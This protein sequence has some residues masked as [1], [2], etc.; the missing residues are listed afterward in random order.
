LDTNL[1]TPYYPNAAALPVEPINVATNEIP[2]NVVVN[3]DPG[4]SF[5]NLPPVAAEAREYTIANKDTLS[6]IAKTH[7]VSLRE[8]SKANPNID[9]ARLKVGQKI[10][11][12]AGTGAPATPAANVAADNSKPAA[13]GKVHIV[14]PGETLTK[15]AKTYGT[16]PK[17]LRSANNMKTDRLLVGQKLKIPVANGAGEGASA[18]PAADQGAR[19]PLLSTTPEVAVTNR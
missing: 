13:T 14:K 4:V 3:V 2:S 16:N 12:P 15:I 7:N 17:A 11:I 19:V 1:L 18:K 8:L 9:P 10:Q 5:S 6:K